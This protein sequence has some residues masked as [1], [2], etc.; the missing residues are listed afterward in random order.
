MKKQYFDENMSIV[1]AEK[2]F[3]SLIDTL[4]PKELREVKEQFFNISKILNSKDIQENKFCM[5]S[6]KI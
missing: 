5:T 3:F 2:K 1:E 4:P 6:Y